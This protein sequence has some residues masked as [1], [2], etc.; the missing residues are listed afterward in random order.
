MKSRI[1]EIKSNELGPTRA[2]AKELL[3]RNVNHLGF[4]SK[5][6]VGT[7]F[8]QVDH[9]GILIIADIQFIVLLGKY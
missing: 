3:A 6:I 7:E 5:D 2:W 9:W 8:K 4:L 1:L